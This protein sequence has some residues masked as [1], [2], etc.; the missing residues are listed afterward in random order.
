MTDIAPTD[1][2][3]TPDSEAL[4]FP[5]WAKLP[6]R[7]FDLVAMVALAVGAVLVL[8]WVLQPR[9]ISSG[10][11]IGFLFGQNV[12]LVG[13][14]WLIAVVWR[15]ASWRS[16]GLVAATRS[17][18][19]RI[20][21][22][23]LLLQFVVILTNVLI[24]LGLGQPFDNPQI[25]LIMP[26]PGDWVAMVGILVATAVL[27]PIAEELT[28]RAVLYGWLRRHVGPILAGVISA[29]AFAVLHGSLVLLPGTFLVGLALAWVYERS[30]S[31]IPCILLHGC[32]NAISTLLVFV[33]AANQ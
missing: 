24:S 13:I 32:F 12:A 6:L 21:P 4:A 14:V 1:P 2:D 9:E 15:R 20:I 16:L 25:A 8:R 28:L 26:N 31:L 18:Y 11:V 23:A 7:F 30:G 17:W 5:P 27:A 22:L 10:L 33:V 29:A 3:G 19:R